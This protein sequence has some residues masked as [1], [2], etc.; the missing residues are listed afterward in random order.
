M[1]AGPVREAAPGSG[2]LPAVGTS[3]VPGRPGAGARGAGTSA[4][5]PSAP[6][7]TP[8]GGTGPRGRSG[9]TGGAGGRGPP[10]STIPGSGPTWSATWSTAVLVTATASVVDASQAESISPLCTAEA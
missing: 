7:G 4:V 5:G 2:A 8:A 10:S 3:A 9:A 1:P 6:R